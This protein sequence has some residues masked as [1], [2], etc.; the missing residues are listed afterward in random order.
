MSAPEFIIEL[1][2]SYIQ[3]LSVIAWPLVFILVF[4]VCWYY[5]LRSLRVFTPRKRMPLTWE[6]LHTFFTN[7]EKHQLAQ[8]SS[9]AKERLRQEQVCR[10]LRLAQLAAERQD[11]KAVV[12]SIAQLTQ[13]AQQ[14]DAEIETLLPEEEKHPS[15]PEPGRVVNE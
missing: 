7:L 10:Q 1:T 14:N 3:L 12:Q 2:K 6:G 4:A 9:D 15:L 8:L 11:E 5:L 13:M